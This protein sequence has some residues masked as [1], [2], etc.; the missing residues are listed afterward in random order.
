VVCIPVHGLGPIAAAV[1]AVTAGIG[2]PPDP[3][4]FTGHRTL[5]RLHGRAACGI[6]GAPF[7]GRFDVTEVELVQSTLAAGGATHEVVATFTR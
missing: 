5:A 4:P 3:R 6:A 1:G 7:S 2:E